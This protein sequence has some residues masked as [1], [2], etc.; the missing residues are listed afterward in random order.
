[1]MSEESQKESQI[2]DE[3]TSAILATSTI[4]TSSLCTGFSRSSR[5]E[6]CWN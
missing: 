1:M 2:K 5:Y 3:Q 6:N 4:I